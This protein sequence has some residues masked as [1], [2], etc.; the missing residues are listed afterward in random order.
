V[1]SGPTLVDVPNVVG[2]P[3]AAAEAALVGAGFGVRETF[4]D[5]GKPKSGNVIS[6]SPASGQAPKGST[7]DIT[8]GQ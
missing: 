1:S 5:A 6:Q 4:Q 2:Q 8:I 3:K 7:V